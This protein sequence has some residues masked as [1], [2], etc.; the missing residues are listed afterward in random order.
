TLFRI[1]QESLTNAA[2]YARA[3][4]VRVHFGCGAQ[5][6]RLEIEDNGRGFRPEQVRS[7]AH[8]L[9]GMRQRTEARGGRFEVRSAP[10]AGTRVTVLLPL[11]APSTVKPQLEVPSFR[12]AP[13]EP[14]IAGV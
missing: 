8:G 7:D 14:G 4:H 12:P 2:K 1:L 10:G 11:A 9:I 13:R 6:C 5:V 3:S